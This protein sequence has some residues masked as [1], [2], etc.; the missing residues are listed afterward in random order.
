MRVQGAV[1]ERAGS[2]ST[3]LFLLVVAASVFVTTLT[4]S[5]VNVVL[6]IIRAELGASAAHI[7]WIVTG[8][9]LA[10]AIGVPIYGRVS[11]VWG[12][13][14]VFVVGLI[15]FIAGGLIC[16]LA[17]NLL[18]LVIGRTVQGIGGAAVPALA[19]VAV[20]KVLPPGKRGSALGLV[21]STVGIGSSVGPIIGG[22]A[23]QFFGWRALFAGSLVLM[24]L[25]IPFA[26]RVLPS[27]DFTTERR[28]D[29]LGGILLGLGAGLFLFGITQGQAAG[30][31]TFSSWGSFL[32]AALA[33]TGFVWRINRAPHPF[34]P[35]AL[36]INRAYVAAMLVG[37]GTSLAYLSAL[38][39]V[40]LL[41]IEVNRL[42]PSAAG[43]VLLPAAVAQALLSAVAGR[44]SDRV[45]VRPLIV[46]GL[47]IMV[48]ATLFISTFVGAS[49]LLIA[50]GVGGLGVGSA[51][52]QSP[53]NNA[54]A[55][56]LPPDAV[57]GGM[58]LFVGASFLGAAT[59]PALSGAF[60]AARQEAG[61]TALNP[62]YAFDA[63]PFSDSFLALT[64]A[65]LI[66]LVAAA[67]LWSNVE[68]DKQARRA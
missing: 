33:T 2:P 39:I 60:L 49:P 56:A 58:G 15:G 21:A 43:L 35:P 12:V 27:G 66:A 6:P 37:S 29:L 22:T 36:F 28:F 44:L 9:A 50:L 19:S 10:Y 16:V 54:A 47:L 11:D 1:I 3:R 41:L 8:Y 48:L 40:P 7:G 38:V 30:F 4:G 5:M 65:L 31:A 26:Q 67:G 45:G 14:R 61:S 20:A 23:G 57:G 18:V 32:G 25:V 42:A 64:L 13:R 53:N 59:G 63:A 52:I 68:R 62:L 46:A 17:P 24:L 51:C 55:N 34:V